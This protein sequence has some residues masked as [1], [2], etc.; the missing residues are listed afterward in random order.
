MGG[1]SDVVTFEGELGRAGRRDVGA[2][3]PRAAPGDRRGDGAR[4]GHAAARGGPVHRPHRRG[5]AGPGDHDPVALR[6]RPQPTPARGGLPPPRGLLGPRR[7]ARRHVVATSC[8]RGAWR[9]TTP[10]TTRSRR[11]ST[12]SP[13]AGPF[14]L[15][16]VHSYNHRRDGADADAGPGR[17]QPRGQR[18]HG[19]HRPADLRSAGR[20]VPGRHPCG[21]P[22]VRPHRRPGE[23]R[24]RGP[25]ARLVRP[26]PLPRRRLRA[27]AGV[28]EDVDGRV[29]RRASTTSG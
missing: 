10:S 26:R 18:R 23:R 4:R 14:V 19:Q 1:T 25:G 5:R 24:L 13:S 22:R 20:A 17:G 16:D 12:R 28:Q 9:R 6:G 8:S 21:C 11:G 2:R 27:G 15:L 7:V 29:D 3:R